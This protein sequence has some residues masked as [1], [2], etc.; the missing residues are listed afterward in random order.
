MVIRCTGMP[1]QVVTTAATSSSPTTGRWVC[2]SFSQ[3][4]LACCMSSRTLR[5]RSLRAAAFS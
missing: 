5:S 2:C 3:A 1:V 4:S